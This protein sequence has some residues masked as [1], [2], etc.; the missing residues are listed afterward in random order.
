[1]LVEKI[2]K[3]KNKNGDDHENKK[4]AEGMKEP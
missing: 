1:M 3:I 4:K 2:N